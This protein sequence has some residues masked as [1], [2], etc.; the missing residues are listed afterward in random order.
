M[1]GLGDTGQHSADYRHAGLCPRRDDLGG[2]AEYPQHLQGGLV[3]PQTVTAV[4]AVKLEEDRSASEM[5]R[6]HQI[7]GDS[8]RQCGLAHSSHPRHH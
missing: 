6:G 5:S 8:Q 4:V 1:P 2:H 7:V 3:R